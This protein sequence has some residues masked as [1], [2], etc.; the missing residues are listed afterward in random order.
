MICV[1]T[2]EGIYILRRD[3]GMT[4]A[5]EVTVINH[6]CGLQCN[7]LVGCLGERLLSQTLCPDTVIGRDVELSPNDLGVL[8]FLT[9]D[10]GDMCISFKAGVEA[11]EEFVLTIVTTGL[12]ET[13]QAFG[14]M[15]VADAFEAFSKKVSEVRLMQ[16]TRVFAI[17]PMSWSFSLRCHCS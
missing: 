1:L 5:D 7:H 15:F 3:E 14:W 4:V 8:N 12:D 10:V 2:T 6:H 17:T 11:L 9:I 13:L 16:K